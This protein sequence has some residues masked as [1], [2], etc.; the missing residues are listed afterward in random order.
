MKIVILILTLSTYLLASKILGYNVYDRTDRADI[1]FTFDTPFKGS[2]KQIRQHNRVILQ[3]SGVTIE[4]PKVKNISS[5]FLQKLT[6]TPATN[7]VQIIANVP[8]NVQMQASKTSDSYGLRLRFAVKKPKNKNVGNTQAGVKPETVLP[9]KSS[10]QFNDSYFIVVAIFII[11]IV[12]LLLLK[13]RVP[14]S[15]GK[16]SSWLFKSKEKSSAPVVKFQKALDQKNRVVML[17]YGNVSY[18]IL[19]GNSNI[20]LDKFVDNKPTDTDEFNQVL[21]REH[22]HIDEY[23]RVENKSSQNRQNAYEDDPLQSYKAKASLLSDWD[24]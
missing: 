20:V 10:T 9:T 19:V 2:L 5:K 17:D 13:N 7:A 22:Q 16:S 1:M 24:K 15:N 21:E 6:I 12:I 23:M 8:K 3:L 4:S 14:T 18:L 11:A